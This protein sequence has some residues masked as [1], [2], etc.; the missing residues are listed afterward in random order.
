MARRD[1]RSVGAGALPAQRDRRGQRR[2]PP[3]EPD[4]RSRSDRADHGGE[5]RSPPPAA[6]GLRG[7]G[8][9]A[10][11]ERGHQSAGGGVRGTPERGR[12]MLGLPNPTLTPYGAV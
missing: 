4:D 2:R 12:V 8:R 7:G 5:A 6:G 3:P 9:P 11:K 1:D 10:P